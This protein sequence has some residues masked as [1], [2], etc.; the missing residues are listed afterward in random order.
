V[1]GNEKQ[2]LLIADPLSSVEPKPEEWLDKDFFKIER[3]KAVAVAYPGTQGTNS[4]KIVRDTDSGDWKLADAKGDEKL[5][6]ARASDVSSPFASPSF[7]DVTPPDPKPD[8][9]GLDK[10]T[11]VTVDTFDDFTYTIKVGSKSGDA[12]YMAMN[13]VA[14]FPKVRVPA[15]DEKPGDITKADKAWAERQ[16]QLEGKLAQNKK[17]ENWTYLVPTW[18][19]EPLLKNRKDLLAVKKDESKPAEKADTSGL[20]NPEEIVGK[21]AK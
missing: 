18:N 6:A 8:V 14:N 2:A 19:L 4:W 9:N 20:S 7:N 11:L 13:V 17:F 21:A 15:K 12:T 16:K 3:P 1:S 10:P 5:D